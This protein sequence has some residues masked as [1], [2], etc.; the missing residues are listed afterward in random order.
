[1]SYKSF[2]GLPAVSSHPCLSK[3]TLVVPLWAP[4]PTCSTQLPQGPLSECLAP[5]SRYE[6]PKTYLW[7]A[8]SVLGLSPAYLPPTPKDKPIL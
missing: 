2:Q 6:L 1:M 4:G 3:T 5:M 7:A 8:A